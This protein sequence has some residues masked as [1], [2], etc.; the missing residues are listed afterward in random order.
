MICGV[1]EAGRGPIAGPVV[2]AAVILDPRKIPAGLKDSKLLKPKAR[3]ALFE[4]I[5]EDALAVG[6]GEASVNEIDSINILQA[7]LLAMQRA[8]SHLSIQPD[9]VLVDGNQC[10]VLPYTTEAIIKGDQKIVQIS[11]ASIIAKVYRDRLML[12]LSRLYPE[13]GF[14]VHAGYP[15]K[16]HVSQLQT[17]GVTPHHRRTFGPVKA[18]VAV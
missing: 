6:V 2:A 3:E 14:D 5:L 18:L 9:I 1:D 12:Q 7:T 17:F 11:A 13:Y 16:F 4:T 15:T 8:V 10:P